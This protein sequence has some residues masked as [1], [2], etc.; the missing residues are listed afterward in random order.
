MQCLSA[1]HG[2]VVHLSVQSPGCSE[3]TQYNTVRLQGKHHRLIKYLILNYVLV[4]VCSETFY[5]CLAFA[6]PTF[7]YTTIA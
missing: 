4:I 3:V 5:H 1:S 7:S 2:V 6:V